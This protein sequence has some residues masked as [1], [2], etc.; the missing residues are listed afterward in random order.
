VQSFIFSSSSIYNIVENGYGLGGQAKTFVGKQKRVSE[1]MTTKRNKI[2][3][4]FKPKHPKVGHWR[5]NKTKISSKEK[6][7]VTDLQLNEYV[8]FSSD[9]YC[10]HQVYPFQISF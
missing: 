10:H 1:Y 5:T 3:Q 2:D 6:N 7:L 9:S 8:Y 4:A